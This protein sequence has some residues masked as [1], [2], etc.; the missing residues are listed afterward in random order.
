MNDQQSINVRNFVGKCWRFS[1]R[2]Y[3]CIREMTEPRLKE[4][5]FFLHLPKCG[6]TSI[7]N[8]IRRRYRASEI[9][10]LDDQACV[11]AAQYLGR[12][13]DDYRRD[14][15]LYYVLQK[16]IRYLS[17][18]FAYS[19]KAYEE[20]RGRWHFMTVLRHPVDRWFSHF[21][22]NKYTPTDRFQIPEDLSAFVETERAFLWGRLYVRNLTEG[23][24]RPDVHTTDTSKAV[25]TAIKALEGFSLVGCL[26]DLN[27]MCAQFEH[28]FGA[29]IRIPVSN[30]NPVSKSKQRG[31]ISEK[32]R[33]RVEEICQPDLEVYNY[34]KARI[35]QG[36][37]SG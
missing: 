4:P 28:R 18:H 12:D 30:S 33:K 8:A 17:G 37:I 24:D 35:A 23:N 14:L 29:K 34:A 19:Q 20:S 27:T 1:Q 6:G 32:I 3:G 16:G 36:C 25:A 5:I 10:H 9:W 15:L 11:K 21:F 2:S 13:L 31:Q 22:Y 7:A 26:E